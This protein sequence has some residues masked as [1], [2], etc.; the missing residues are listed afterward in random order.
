[1]VLL[2]GARGCA[3]RAPPAA[4]PTGRHD[5]RGVVQRTAVQSYVVRVVTPIPGGVRL[6]LSLNGSGPHLYGPDVSPVTV[7]LT[8]DTNDRL[9]LRIVDPR[10]ARWEVPPQARS[11]GG[12]GGSSGSCE[13]RRA[14]RV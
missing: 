13:R 3:A 11:R 4:S 12:G 6:E 14:G 7:T 1:M 2:C 10:A 9:R 5:R 8:M